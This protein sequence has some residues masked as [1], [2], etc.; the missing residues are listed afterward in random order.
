MHSALLEIIIFLVA[1]VCLVPLF[2]AIGLGAI[3]A[4]LFAGIIIGPSALGLIEDP[5]TILRFSELGVVFLL[6][7]IGLELN[8]RK[9]W[10]LRKSVFGLGAMQ[11]IISGGVLTALAFYALD[12]SLNASI[13]AGFGLG[14]SSTAFGLQLLEEK[15]QLKTMHGQGSFS[16]LLF[17]DMSVVPLLALVS[18][19][20]GGSSGEMTVFDFVVMLLTIAGFVVV[21]IFFVRHIFSY[22]AKSRVQE[23]FTAMALLIVIGSAIIM[24]HAGLSMGMGAFLAG[25]LLA[26]SEYRHELETNLQPFKG[27]LLGLF[28]I[29]VGMSLNLITVLEKPFLLMALVMV[30]MLAK[31]GIIY[32]LGRIY[33]FPRE[34]A[35]NM[36]FTLPQGGEF[37]FVLFAAAI[38]Q[39]LFAEDIAAILN[40]SVTISMAL[41]PLFFSLNQKF[42]RTYSDLSERPYDVIDA[43]ETEIIIAGYGRFGQIVSRFLKSQNVKFTI[44]EHSAAQVDTARKY[45]TKVFYGD[46]SRKDIVESAGAKTAKIFVL[47]I[48]DPEKSIKTAKM[49]KEHY[50]HL[51]IIARVRNRQHAI[52]LL[53]LGI[54]N[55]HRETYLTSLEVAKEVL[56]AR[57]GVREKI[58]KKLALFRKHDENIL[59]EQ[60]IHREDEKKM[61]SFTN[62]ANAELD[63]IL[64]ADDLSSDRSQDKQLGD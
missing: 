55:V 53:A 45:G 25:V 58:N 64:R 35:R 47:A 29:A 43:S 41:T 12:L 27:L 39:N 51:E 8:P 17:Q 40:A 6:F 46:A 24:E 26:N 20:G 56:L 48:D 50:P 30:F 37:A 62:Q 2:K 38:N 22:I 14:L 21:G 19:M 61:I 60:L 23:V 15:R 31:S 11:L 32:L 54:E 33:K 44:L 57:G 28:F 49:I 7:L 9:L 18:Y 42:L 34:S 5:K 16:I 36:A 10:Q 3:L 13:I 59:R 4:Y 63:Q 1:A 52:E